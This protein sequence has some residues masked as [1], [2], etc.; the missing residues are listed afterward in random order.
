MLLE[1]IART[2]RELEYVVAEL[3][4]DRRISAVRG[5]SLGACVA[6]GAFGLDVPFC[7]G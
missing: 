6:L 7:A 4:A 5:E 2:A 3:Q 1:V